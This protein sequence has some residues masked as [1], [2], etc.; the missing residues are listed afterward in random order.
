MKRPSSCTPQARR[1]QS[2][3]STSA[4]T[5]CAVL[6]AFALQLFCLVWQGSPGEE[7]PD[8]RPGCLQAPG[9]CNYPPHTGGPIADSAVLQACC[10]RAQRLLAHRVAQHYGLETTTTSD[11]GEAQVKVRAMKGPNTGLPQVGANLSLNFCLVTRCLDI[12]SDMASC[13]QAF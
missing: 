9:Y 13:L 8:D 11:A 10:L 12:L 6:P 2:A 1:L 5:P 3:P 7:Q 4:W